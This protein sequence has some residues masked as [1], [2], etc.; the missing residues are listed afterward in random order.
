MHPVKAAVQAQHRAV[1]LVQQQYR[2]VYWVLQYME[3][4][5]EEGV[6]RGATRVIGNS[7]VLPRCTDV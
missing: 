7:R 6:A 2:A 4:Q 3:A 5:M 1:H